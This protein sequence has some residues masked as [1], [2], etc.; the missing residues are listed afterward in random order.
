MIVKVV[1]GCRRAVTSELPVRAVI[2]CM[3][4]RHEMAA[5][6]DVQACDFGRHSGEQLQEAGCCLGQG[7]AN[8]DE[9]E[10]WQLLAD[11]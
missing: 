2:G 6:A 10:R 9:I 8:V 7:E 11:G 3:Q 1:A 4:L 5:G